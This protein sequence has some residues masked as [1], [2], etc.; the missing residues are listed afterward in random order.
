MSF[1]LFILYVLLDWWAEIFYFKIRI[2]Q[3]C[4]FCTKLLN[5]CNVVPILI[6]CTTVLLFLQTKSWCVMLG[7]REN[8]RQHRCTSKGL[9]FVMRFATRHPVVAKVWPGKYKHPIQLI[10]FKKKVG[11]TYVEDDH[12]AA[13]PG[14]LR[15]KIHFQEKKTEIFD[16][17]TFFE[18]RAWCAWRQPDN[19]EF[20]RMFLHHRN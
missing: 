4:F 5:K 3:K 6:N 9:T 15:G 14:R 19:V 7:V 11:D 1:N 20:G 18:N 12:G 10:H 8:W 17:I 13:I 2:L 16:K